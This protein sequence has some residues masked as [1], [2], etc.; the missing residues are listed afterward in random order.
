MRVN[1]IVDKLGLEVI[2][3]D[4]LA[5][6]V[7]GAY[8]GD[9]LSNVMARAE[10]GNLWLTIQGHQNVVAVALLADVAAVIVV[11]GMT[12]EDAAVARAEEKGVNILRSELSAYELAV[13]LVKMGI[14]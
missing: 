6:E 13:K 11:E 1:E 7:S 10:E 2:A 4:S 9:L 14:E 3:A 8:I 12:V 5:R